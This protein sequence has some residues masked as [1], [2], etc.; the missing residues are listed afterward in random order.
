V[1]VYVYITIDET[2]KKKKKAWRGKEFNRKGILTFIRKKL[3]NNLSLEIQMN[4][5]NNERRT[6]KK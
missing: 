4:N 3:R 2:V 6:S 1:S 5:S